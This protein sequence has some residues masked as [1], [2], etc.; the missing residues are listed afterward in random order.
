MK[1]S[2]TYP[3]MHDYISEQYF[4]RSLNKLSSNR[5]QRL[6]KVSTTIKGVYYYFSRE[7]FLFVKFF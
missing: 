6:V 3:W 5:Y 4:L 2:F 7:Q 1:D